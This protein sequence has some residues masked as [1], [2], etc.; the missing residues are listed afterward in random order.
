[1]KVLEYL[2]YSIRGV[3]PVPWINR[4]AGSESAITVTAG[5][6]KATLSVCV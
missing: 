2:M 5:E 1:M 3:S 6:L 4:D